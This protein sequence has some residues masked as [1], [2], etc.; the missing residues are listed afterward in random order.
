[1]N[2]DSVN[3]VL[4]IVLIVLFVVVLVALALFF[5]RGLSRGWRY[6]TYRVIA[7]AVLILI[8]FLALGP[9]AEA[10]GTWDMTSFGIG[11]ITIP[12]NNGSKSGSASGTFGTPF[13]A[14]A[15]LIS[16]TL[17]FYDVNM[18]PEQLNA[19]AYSL[20]KS[21][22][23]LVLLS[24]DGLLLLTLGNLFVMLLWH[25]AFIHII[26]KEKRK[27]SYKKGRLI[28]AFEDLV[29]GLVVGAMFIFPLTS[30][31]NSLNYGFKK[32]DETSTSSV[33]ANNETYNTIKGV[34][35]TYDNS[36]FAKVFFGWTVDSS[37][38]TFDV[39]L[40]DF[41]TKG[42]YDKASVS[43]VN[44]LS[45][46]GKIGT[47]LLKSGI[48]SS[49]GFDK[50]KVPL[51]LLSD[52]APEL[53]RDLGQS[54]LI[55]GILPYAL[56]VL[57]NM[58]AV[59]QYVKTNSA[60][61]FASCDYSLTFNTLADLYQGL[62]DSNV[63]QSTVF[64][65]EGNFQGTAAVV[66]AAF[67]KGI[68]TPMENLINALDGDKL[69]IFDLVIESVVYV[70]SCNAYKA[71]QADPTAYENQLTLADFFPDVAGYDSDGDGTPD[72]VP[73]S[74][75]NIAWGKQ[76]A[77]LYDSICTVAQNDDTLLDTLTTGLGTDAYSINV[78]SLLSGIVDHLDAYGSA[79]FGVQ[80]S[81]VNG[82]QK[83]ESTTS[84][85]SS[86]TSSA[87][88]LD[89]SFLE[90][91]MPKVL[92][93][94]EKTINDAFS[95]T[96]TTSAISLSE[97][98]AKLCVDDLTERTANVK[99]EFGHVYTV[100][101]DIVGTEDGK[102]FLK[103]IQDLPGIYF[104]PDGGFLGI[105][106]GLAEGLCDGLA[107]LDNSKLAS[108]IIPGVF[109][110]FLSG[111]SSPIKKALGIDL[112]L[113]FSSNAGT[114][115]ANLLRV[116]VNNQDVITYLL[117]HTAAITAANADQ[118]LTTLL[119][120]KH[121][122]DAGNETYQIS[123]LL[124]ALFANPIICTDGKVNDNVISILSAVL[125]KLDSSGTYSDKLKSA[126][127]NVDL[128]D[129]VDAMVTVLE[130]AS[131]GGVLSKVL[132]FSSTKNMKTLST[133][134]FTTLFGKI[135]ASKI[136]TTFLGTYLDKTVLSNIDYLSDAQAAGIAF[137]NVTDWSK[138]GAA[139][140]ALIKA[141][142]EIG[143]L[144]NIDYLHSD[145]S[146]IASILKGLAGSGMFVKTANGTTTYLFPSYMAKKMVSYFTSSA[147]F[148]SYFADAGTSDYT[149][150]NN[151]SRFTAD[152]KALNSAVAWTDAG[153][154]ADKIAAI[155]TYT[156]RFGDFDKIS[157]D[158]DWREVNPNNLTGLF[159]AVASS[160]SFG[161][162]LT[163]HLY[164]KVSEALSAS[165]AAFKDSNLDYILADTTTTQNRIDE[166]AYLGDIL[167]AALDPVY[168]LLDKTTGK[169][170][171]T[172]I[173]LQDVSADFFVDPLLTG[174][175]SSAVFN[176]R[177]SGCD[178][179]AFEEEYSSILV[180]ATLYDTADQANAIIKTL[181][182]SD[183]AAT[184]ANWKNEITNL[185]TTLNDIQAL[186]LDIANLSFSSLFSSS[187]SAAT[188]E[189]NR[190]KVEKTLR[191][192]NSCA[193]LYAALPA[194][195]KK[196]VQKINKAS[197][198][199][200]DSANFEYKKDNS[201]NLLAYDD[202][203]ITRLSYIM[204]DAMVV[205]FAS[206]L[207]VSSLKSNAYLSNLLE[208][209]A[210]SS[211]FNTT[212]DTKTGAMTSFEK[213]IDKVLL[214]S[215]Y[216]GDSTDQAVV[217][218]VK[219]VVLNVKTTTKGW[220]GDTGEIKALEAVA[221]S[222]PNDP[223]GNELDLQ[224]FSLTNYFGTDAT[225]K[226]NQRLAL[227]QFLDNVNAC[228]LLYPGLAGKIST[229][230][231]SIN[232]GSISLTGANTYYNGHFKN[233]AT[234]YPT[235]GNVY[236]EKEITALTTLFKD[237]SSL[238]STVNLSDISKIPADN[239]TT[240]LADLT[241]SRVFNTSAD[242]TS[243][244]V[245]QKVISQA[246][247]AGGSLDQ[248]YYY[249]SN[250]KDI[251]G[252]TAKN[253]DSSAAKADYLA[254]S[255]FTLDSTSYTI[256]DAHIALLTG[257]SGS[258]R[259]VLKTVQSGSIA[260]AL[261]NNSYS[262][263]SVT[264]LENLLGALNGCKLF[265][266]CVP[267]LLANALT[268]SLASSIPLVDM[269]L[270]NPY[271]C[272]YRPTSGFT[273]GTSKTFSYDTNGNETF[274]LVSYDNAYDEEEITTLAT[275]VHDMDD[276]SVTALFG[277]SKLSS[278][279]YSEA[280]LQTMNSLLSL[281]SSSY[282]F[283]LGG[284]YGGDASVPSTNLSVPNDL[285]VFEQALFNFYSQS[286]LADRAYDSA[287]DYQT[288]NAAIKLY[289]ATK[290]FE[291]GQGDTLHP[292]NWG[293]EIDALTVHKTNDVDDG[294]LLW[295]ALVDNTEISSL[296]KS[297][298]NF[299][300]SGNLS[301]FKDVSPSALGA[302]LNAMNQLDLVNDA[303]PYSVAG[304]VEDSLNFRKYSTVSFT[305]VALSGTSYNSELL[306]QRGRYNGLSITLSSEL[307]NSA[308]LKVTA[309]DEIGSTSVFAITL[310]N[311]TS[312]T[313]VYTF[314]MGA[315]Y[316]YYFAITVS[317]ATLSSMDYSFNSS[318]YILSQSQ[319]NS[320]DSSG[321]T[322]IDV[323]TDFAGSIYITKSGGTRGYVDFSSDEDVT[324][325]FTSGNKFSS[326]LRYLSDAN[327]FYTRNFYQN[328]YSQATS[329]S[330]AFASRDIVFRRMLKF[331]TT[332]NGASYT[333]DFGKYLDESGADPAT[334][335]GAKAIFTSASYSADT[336]GDWLNAQI[337]D[338]TKTEGL[339]EAVGEIPLGSY[340]LPQVHSWV[341]A[342]TTSVS[343][344]MN[345]TAL[346][347]G[348]TAAATGSSLL[349]KY[350]AAGEA[351]R[352]IN[353]ELAYL[354]SGSYF[355]SMNPSASAMSNAS[356]NRST[357]LATGWADP[358][359]YNDNF[360][361]LGTT[362]R[363]AS[364]A[365]AALTILYDY[366]ETAAILKL[367]NAVNS[368]ATTISLA[369]KTTI[370]GYF[371]TLDAYLL[372]G[373]SDEKALVQVLYLGT[374]YDYYLNRS[375]YHANLGAGEVDGF[376]LPNGTHT[377]ASTENAILTA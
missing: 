246:L 351:Q 197:D 97:V 116:Y 123:N 236:T 215:G 224:A 268:G 261:K 172:T 148:G 170:A 189:A 338:L 251:A 312:G 364:S 273:Y 371:S 113:D 212:T 198:Y 202:S 231:S 36:L 320:K 178:Y 184:L 74:F 121:E 38:K 313:A 147:S 94:L 69:K 347:N 264:D 356:T 138:E 160:N 300:K 119:S 298:S 85:S 358:S 139:L 221:S 82:L 13:N 75:K 191:D 217:D 227:E 272:Y 120:F 42:T 33:S 194:I 14:I 360:A 284:A 126:L 310:K 252:N 162:I 187:N 285:T 79:L 122:D 196:A 216:Y 112:T 263:L 65:A 125:N 307:A 362:S 131:T 57:S 299:S 41:F 377:L 39:N 96:N 67:S 278:L 372:V 31:V 104:D 293:A 267:N 326:V 80:S 101:K 164:E 314:D 25:I 12:L 349:G 288:S 40:T 154:E 342:F 260:D 276:P 291:K 168:G 45:S 234:T 3:Q 374:T 317:G 192:F 64:D 303:V 370:S 143:D 124:K 28:S 52:A 229:S 244:P 95:F 156:L 296:V 103:N 242:G 235:L 165:E 361:L 163:Y 10:I 102:A 253:Y 84:T 257:A 334:Y 266:D 4:N 289:N 373:T 239:V 325:F 332:Y 9:I 153:G 15:S 60:I 233:D 58:D 8:A 220:T 134:D 2:L 195:L 100:I 176:T 337:S 279:D 118:T 203:E 17:K 287:Y 368:G 301:N 222:L 114:N 238:D 249:A 204:E 72:K 304:L 188:N 292:G 175:A 243:Q 149:N 30:I 145:P 150:A 161:P 22:V 56:S 183:Q 127:Q 29:I 140:D 159:K 206:T 93:I 290:A 218:N 269:S 210:A 19:Y 309:Y 193:T 55:N 190:V 105:K 322:A 376:F 180:T 319:F 339:Y 306:G 185:C 1:M 271:Y 359:F 16:D 344:V 348:M 35:D 99:E 144:S 7:F 270:A 331:L 247:L 241:Q 341:E 59:A 108:A 280:D 258:L 111:D 346:E 353:A 182:G 262:A 32:A 129:E 77:Y 277:N 90:N 142:A 283:N 369:D 23:M 50:T 340:T 201:G 78:N 136:L 63:V 295:T 302:M 88:L 199:G 237:A 146:S 230:I 135:N 366:I 158:T 76:L 98:K 281:L 350:L 245:A 282:V 255:Y 44:E 5:L 62:L 286:G 73:D 91:A 27:E 214:D 130:T 345:Y 173:K 133:I 354:K 327:G 328:D 132:S 318:N 89:C 250:P 71:A 321:K 157:A 181:R 155:I 274:A 186:N 363:T 265:Q 294:G 24:I 256:S 66:K 110:G 171:Q 305:G 213:T 324:T 46:M 109:K 92:N 26:P 259:T 18:D 128:S 316:P 169:L 365:N 228:Q 343:G 81:S 297:N 21:I 248:V 115:I 352:F 240:L 355:T 61:D 174:M 223:S 152:F 137:S 311:H 34:V 219:T 330:Y 357:L 232:T 254:K 308:D 209:L 226:E 37:G 107:D 11:T 70:A 86:S 166:I 367:S 200:L 48:L 53:L 68:T 117:S 336:E 211:I 323:I 141:A 87:C 20:A 315:A 177:K 207:S 83:A 51:L 225:T 49:S 47:V 151:Y 43:I 335:S 329:S 208:N 179:T 205:D 333:M 167:T 54:N 106:Q 6:G 275:L 375:Y